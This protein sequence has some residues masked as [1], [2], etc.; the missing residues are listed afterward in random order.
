MTSVEA[1]AHQNAIRSLKEGEAL[2]VTQY[3]ST[4]HIF[5]YIILLRFFVSFHPNLFLGADLFL[6]TVC[7]SVVCLPNRYTS[8]E[9]WLFNR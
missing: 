3:N 8:I 2:F 4:V 7:I 1:N 6:C 5:M 9:T